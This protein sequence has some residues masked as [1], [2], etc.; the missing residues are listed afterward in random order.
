V[1]KGHFKG[2][3]KALYAESTPVR[4]R[5]CT[6]IKVTT[7]VVNHCILISQTPQDA[8]GGLFDTVYKEMVT[9]AR[10]RK[11]RKMVLNKNSNCVI[12]KNPITCIILLQSI[13]STGKN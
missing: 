1:E 9:I 10:S 4:Y 5:Y 12:I 7:K 13:P 11:V 6:M 8:V 3:V 2:T